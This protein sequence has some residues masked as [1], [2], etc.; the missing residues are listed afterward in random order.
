MIDDQ[1]PVVFADG[2]PSRLPSRQVPVGTVFV[3]VSEQWLWE[4]PL[5]TRGNGPNEARHVPIE[6][7]LVLE[8]FVE[9]YRGRMSPAGTCGASEHDRHP[10]GLA[11]GSS[12]CNGATLRHRLMMTPSGRVIEMFTLSAVF[13]AP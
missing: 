7:A 6:R 4:L 10:W 2:A 1:T 13:D 11:R 9:F 3:Y 12:A 5:V 8:Q